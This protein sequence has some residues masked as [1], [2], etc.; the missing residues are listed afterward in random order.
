VIHLHVFEGM[1]FQEAADAMGE[2][3]NTIASRYRYAVEKLRAAFR[4]TAERR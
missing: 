3:I 2:S 4:S 1:T